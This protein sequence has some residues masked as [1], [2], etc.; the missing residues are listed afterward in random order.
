MVGQRR[1][2]DFLFRGKKIKEVT[3]FHLFEIAAT[4]IIERSTSPK[5][6]DKYIVGLEAKVMKVF[7]L[8][9]SSFSIS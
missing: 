6:D 5:R 8:R 4:K 2:P 3:K 9:S 7:M 1:G